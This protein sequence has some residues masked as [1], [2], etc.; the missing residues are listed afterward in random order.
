MTDAGMTASTSPPA[1]RGPIVRWR[2]ESGTWTYGRVLERRGQSVRI[3]HG[4]G[5]HEIRRWLAETEIEAVDESRFR[6]S[7]RYPVTRHRRTPNPD[8]LTLGLPA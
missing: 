7:P 8:Q 4:S 2:G 6:W 3:V 5:P 1:L